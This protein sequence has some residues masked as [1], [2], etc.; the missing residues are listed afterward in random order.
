VAPSK[1][2][3][4]KEVT[5]KVGTSKRVN[6]EPR[7]VHKKFR[8]YHYG[9]NPETNAKTTRIFS[10]KPKPAKGNTPKSALPQ[11]K[12]PP[13]D[14]EHWSV[15]GQRILGGAARSNQRGEGGDTGRLHLEVKGGETEFADR[16]YHNNRDN[17][18]LG[19]RRCPNGKKQDSLI[20]EI[21]AKRRHSDPFGE[22]CGVGAL[23]G[24]DREEGHP[25]GRLLQ[26]PKE[27]RQ[28]IGRAR[29]LSAAGDD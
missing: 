26:D 6:G 21:L 13:T 12:V 23:F 15:E 5:E 27:H 18:N 17:D 3:I 8:H 14:R 28:G 20:I 19:G 16:G 9:P 24:G 22:T 10:Q 4:L 1:E 11:K 25:T 7:L 29:R 2:P